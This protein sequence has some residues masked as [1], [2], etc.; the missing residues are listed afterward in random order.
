LWILEFRAVPGK[1][2]L[3]GWN[4]TW[5]WG[6][7]QHN[8]IFFYGTESIWI[9]LETPPTHI[10]LIHFSSTP[11]CPFSWN[12]PYGFLILD[13]KKK[14]FKYFVGILILWIALPI[15]YTKLNVQWIK[16]IP[17]YFPRE[18]VP[19]QIDLQGER[20]PQQILHKLLHRLKHSTHF[21]ANILMFIRDAYFPPFFLCLQ[22]C[23]RFLCENMKMH[24]LVLFP[25]RSSKI[26]TFCDNTLQNLMAKF[27]KSYSFW[28]KPM[29]CWL[30]MKQ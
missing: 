13:R 1:R 6:Y 25:V 15:K 18:D 3:G 4:G 12:S 10:I 23:N 14:P 5:K 24:K 21:W 26:Q 30:H 20:L 11:R 27:T 2:V 22:Y 9:F 7:H 19:A 8:F 29:L 17:H 16:I 28:W